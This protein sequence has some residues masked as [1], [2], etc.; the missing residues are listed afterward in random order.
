MNFYKINTTRHP[1]LGG[2]L[3]GSLVLGATL[4]SATASAQE[5]SAQEIAP[6]ADA[7]ISAGQKAPTLGWSKES[8]LL[9]TVRSATYETP[10]DSFDAF[11]G[12]ATYTG[13]QVEVGYDF[14]AALL[15]GLRGYIIYSGGG[16]PSISRFDGALDLKWRRDLVMAAVDFGPELWGVFRPSLRVGGGYSLQTLKTEVHKT[17]RTGRVPGAAGFG[18][19]NLALYTPREFLGSAQVGLVVEAGGMLQTGATFDNMEENGSTGGDW[20]HKQASLGELNASGRFATV[21][22]EL[23]ISF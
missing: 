14:G 4:L 11:G 15:P 22:V 12:D 10:H 18:A 6:S 2:L 5:P 21:G 3:V 13:V 17:A 23:N 9:A 8:A 16:H 7:H 20:T 1:L 19:V